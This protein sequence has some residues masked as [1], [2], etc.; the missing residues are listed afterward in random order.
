MMIAKD[1]RAVARG[2]LQ[3][4]WGTAVLVSFVALLLGGSTGVNFNLIFNSASSASGNSTNSY[5]YYS[6]PSYMYGFFAFWASIAVVFVIITL[7]VG[8]A[9]TLGYCQFNIDLVTKRQPLN[10]STLFSRFSFFL[11]AFLLQLA[12]SVFTFLW[13]L[14]LVVPGIMAAY[15]YSMAGFL[16]AQ[17][18]E[19]GVMEAITMSKN[20]MRGNRWR[21]FCLQ[22][23]FIGWMF[24][25]SM[26]FGIG[27]L[28]LNPYMA[29]ATAAFYLDLTRQLPGTQGYPQGY[30]QGYGYP[31]YPTQQPNMYQ[32]YPG[33]A[34]QGYAPQGY[35]QQPQGY[36][37]PRQPQGYA[38]QGAPQGYPQQPPYPQQG[39]PQQPQG[40]A[41]P[42]PPA[43]PAPQNGD[44][45]QNN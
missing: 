42:A 12:I 4:N 22:I 27:L 7:I 16:M 29:A 23:S 38:P 25:C 2:A 41:P 34:P 31:Q 30:P 26:T 32:S 6:I 1:Y 19:L 45:T 44:E 21:L 39:Y 10:F 40:Y 17:N 36:A 28:F 9:T 35:P 20:M 11:K 18:P 33:A 14:L 5:Y 3:G 24:L 15:S 13:S 8:G 37:P 43:P